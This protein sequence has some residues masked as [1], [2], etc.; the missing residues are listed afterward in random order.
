MKIKDSNDN[1]AYGNISEED[2]NNIYIN[3]FKTEGTEA[4]EKSCNKCK[5]TNKSI[6]YKW[7][8]NNNT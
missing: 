7:W 4:S 5:S 3:L 8:Y 6:N 1:Q 2:D